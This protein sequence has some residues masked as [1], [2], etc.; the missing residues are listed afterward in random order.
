MAVVF[1]Y[2]LFESLAPFAILFNGGWPR[3]VEGLVFAVVAAIIYPR[4]GRRGAAISLAVLGTYFLVV[5]VYASVALRQRQVVGE[6]GM[7]VLGLLLVSLAFQVWRAGR[8]R[9]SSVARDV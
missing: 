9:Q 4:L 6:I 8:G 3:T 5:A 1:Y 2:V 7:A